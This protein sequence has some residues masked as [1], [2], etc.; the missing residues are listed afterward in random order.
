MTSV[1]RFGMLDQRFERLMKDSRSK[2]YK[3]AVGFTRNKTDAEDLLQETLIKVYMNLEKLDN[4]GRFM[5]WA[6]QIMRRVYLDKRR[7]DNRRPQTTSFDEINTHFGCEI[8]YADPKVDIESEVMLDMVQGMKS[9]QIRAMMST[10]EPAYRET[11]SLNTYSNA[12]PL[13]IAGSGADGMDYTA[14]ALSTN[15]AEGTVK[16][17]ISRAKRALAA[18]AK[19][20]GIGQD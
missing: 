15:T 12:N 18:V 3:F 19:D 16:S 14:I 17:R 4:E 11:L 10:L 8:D 9:R 6:V 5:S 1:E 7:Y 13:D 20:Y 2:L